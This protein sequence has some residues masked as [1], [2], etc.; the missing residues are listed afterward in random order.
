MSELGRLERID[1]LRTVWAHE[2]LDFTPWLCKEENLSLLAEALNLDGLEL[3]SREVG[4]GDFSADIL[5]RDVTLE[6]GLV[7]IENMFGRSDHDHLG[8]CLTYASGLK[9]QTVVLIAEAI[10]EE[11]RATLDWLNDITDDT[12]SF[13]ACEL[14]LWKIGNSHPAPKFNIVVQPNDWE[15]RLKNNTQRPITELGNLYLRYWSSFHDHLSNST[16]RYDLRLQKIKP[17]PGTSFAIG[18][19]GVGLAVILYPNDNRIQLELT[20]NGSEALNR[21]KQLSNDKEP[22]QHELGFDLNWDEQNSKRQRIWCTLDNQDIKNESEWSNQHQKTLNKL[23]AMKS[24]F[25]SRV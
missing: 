14:E 7:L 22:I 2:A 6:G 11:H 5:A 3:E 19:A 13:F 24:V 25:Q 20:L 21:L 4:V 9:A 12:H 23:A 15:K 1:N 16:H 10:R 18:R 17:V 8:K